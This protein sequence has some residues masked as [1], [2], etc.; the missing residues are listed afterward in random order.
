MKKQLSLKNTTICI[1]TALLITLSSFAGAANIWDW[2]EQFQ[3]KYGHV[4]LH[5]PRYV[6]YDN[7]LSARE[8]LYIRENGYELKVMRRSSREDFVKALLQSGLYPA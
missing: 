2:T 6:V 1:L 4:I 3:L 7:W 8:G 5:T